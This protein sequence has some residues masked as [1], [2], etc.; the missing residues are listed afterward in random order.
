MSNRLPQRGAGERAGQETHAVD[1]TNRAVLLEIEQR[2]GLGQAR[3]DA[4]Q[5]CEGACLQRCNLKRILGPE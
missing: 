3:R 1:G 2:I 5:R 4:S